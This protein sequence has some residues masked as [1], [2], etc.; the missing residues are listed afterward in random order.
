MTD[1]RTVI[2]VAFLETGGLK[3]LNCV[4]M[5][6]APGL[7]V[8]HSKRCVPEFS[9]CLLNTILPIHNFRHGSWKLYCKSPLLV[10]KLEF[11]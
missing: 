3:K 8:Q 11:I 1:L 7:I 5:M 2:V 4:Q 10:F 6:S 9:W